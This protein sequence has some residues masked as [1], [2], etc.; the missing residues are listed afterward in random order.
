MARHTLAKVGVAGSVL[1]LASAVC[2]VL[3]LLFIII[4]LGGPWVA[5]FGAVAS[6]GYYLVGVT[7]LVLVLALFNAIRHQDKGRSYALIF[8]GL[9]LTLVAWLIIANEGTINSVLIEL[10]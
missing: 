8:T 1:S 2:C 5:Y 6:I 4:G 10:T 7:V 9:V 3:P